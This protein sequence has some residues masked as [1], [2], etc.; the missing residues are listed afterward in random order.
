MIIHTKSIEIKNLD[1]MREKSQDE[2]NI[3]L[4]EVDKLDKELSDL[5]IKMAKLKWRKTE[6]LEESK[7]DDRKIE[8]YEEKKQKLKGKR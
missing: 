1:S 7:V 4:N 6:L 2:K 3:K 5:E 8:K